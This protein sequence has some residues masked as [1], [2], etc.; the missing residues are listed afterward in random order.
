MTSECVKASIRIAPP[1]RRCLQDTDYVNN[2]YSKQNIRE[3][4]Y[5]GNDG[6]PL[7]RRADI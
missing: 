7:L 5:Y 6:V 3:E 2:K 4:G 1:K